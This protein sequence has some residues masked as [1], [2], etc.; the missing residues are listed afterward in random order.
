MAATLTS[1]PPP[2]EKAEMARTSGQ[3]LAPLA[4]DVAAGYVHG[5]RNLWGLA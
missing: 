5:P 1:V 3:R 4:K 2:K